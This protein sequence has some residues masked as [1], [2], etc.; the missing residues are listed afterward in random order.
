MRYGEDEKQRAEQHAYSE[1]VPLV[2]AIIAAARPT[3]GW[4]ENGVLST[5]TF[6]ANCK[7][8]L[9]LVEFTPAKSSQ[10]SPKAPTP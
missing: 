9:D 3:E 2:P 10:S 7:T 6:V 1:A 5:E 4:V 8:V